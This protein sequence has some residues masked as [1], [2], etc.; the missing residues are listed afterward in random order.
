MSL[1]D[2]FQPIEWTDAMTIGVATID[3]QHHFL[4]DTLQH[5]NEALLK[6]HNNVLLSQVARDLLSYAIMHFETEEELMQR[7]GYEAACPEEAHTH[8]EQH[9]AF[10]RRVVAI[11]DQLREGREV[12][13][14]EVLEF[15]N[16]WLRDHVL[17][18]DQL[19]GA[20]LRQAMN[21]T[22]PEPDH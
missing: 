22:D 1:K 7:Y 10:S 13:R 16:N 6:D 19:L 4:V 5:A 12:S 17:G 8:I 20:F 11:N 21:E 18:I 14:V 15:L 9:R 2:P 3:K